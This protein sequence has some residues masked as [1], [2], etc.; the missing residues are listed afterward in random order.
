VKL[1]TG[2]TL[3]FI[4]QFGL[5]CIAQKNTFGISIIQDGKVIQPGLMNEV[6]LS[7]TPFK[8]QVVLNKLAG[9]HLFAAFKD[10][11]Y[12]L[13]NNDSIP[14]FVDIPAMTMA[15]NS[16]NPDQELLINDEGWA[17]WFYDPKLDWHRFDKD[18]VIEGDN[19][20]ATKTVKQFYDVVSGKPMPVAE[21]KDPLYLFFMATQDD[22]SNN[23]IK[24][25]QR[26]KIRINWK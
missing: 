12:K 11:I 22:K 10:S 23:P 1:K 8:I 16:F 3:L 19:I 4:F 21:V 24:V 20:T 18:V 9:V 17:F 6:V 13:G 7:K 25:L 14:G 15:E 2:L 5:F 26:Y